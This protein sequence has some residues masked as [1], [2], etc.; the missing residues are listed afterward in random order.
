MEKRITDFFRGY[1]R[2]RIAGNHY[3]RFLN[4]CAYHD[5]VL[6]NLLP[7][8]EAYEAF[9]ARKDFK[10]L[11]TIV[12][13]SH[14][15]VKI[16]ER[17]GLP[18]FIHRNRKRKVYVLGIAAAMAFLFWLSAHI[19]NISIDGNLSQTDDVIFEYLSNAGIYHGMWKS[20]VDCKELAADIRNCF[21]EFAWVAAELKGTRLVIHVKEGILKE[22]SEEDIQN[23]TEPSSLAASCSGTVESIYVRR[24]TPLVKVGDEVE[25]GTI[26]VSGALPIY[27]DS[28]EIAAYQY[29][30]SDADIVIKTQRTYQDELPLI[31]EEKEYTG[32]E[33]ISWL[34]R[35]GDTPFSLPDSFGSFAQ[36]DTVSSLTQLRI[37]DNFYL[38]FYIQKFTARE[39][40]NKE[41]QYTKEQAKE[42]LNRNFR[43]F[44][45]NLNEKGVQ[46]FEND[47]R[48]EWTE[49]SAIASGIL[50]T[51]EN[52]V[53][54]VK[55]DSMEEELQQNEYG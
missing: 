11:K 17:H 9:I 26:L 18:F 15:A 54:R 46:I 2:I 30:A 4:L 31:G 24:G 55:T 7:V 38:P 28:Q 35:I 33:K 48:I 34:F 41:I 27:N 21:H 42:I 16:T 22:E 6:W 8:G 39:Y 23:K 47:V 3:D 37:S 19:W 43:Y 14:A 36:Y 53:S 51:G 50:T 20:Q 29:V 32:R 49:K 52:A 45:Q 40:E 10:K 25:R 44:V 5:I 13:K 1:V 12:R